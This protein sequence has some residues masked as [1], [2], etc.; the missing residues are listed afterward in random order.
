MPRT[1]EDPSL[2]VAECLSQLP[3]TGLRLPVPRSSLEGLHVRS[4]SEAGG[5][6]AQRTPDARQGA[7]DGAGGAGAPFLVLEGRL[8]TRNPGWSLRDGECPLAG[9]SAV[10]WTTGEVAWTATCGSARCYRCS[11]IVSGRTFALARRAMGELEEKRVRFVTLTLA[12]EEWDSLRKRM[13]DLVQYLRR[14]GIRVNWLWVVEEGSET[15]MK[16]IHCVQWGDF[17]PWRDLLGWWGA[18]V[19]VE[20]SDAAVGYLGK[21]I[22]RYLGKGLDGDREAIEGHMNLNG[23][24]AAHWSRGF[25]AGLSREAF[26]REHRLPGI[27]FLRNEPIGEA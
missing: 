13:K 15:G 2:Q 26:A 24:R 6:L 19:Q 18:R 4:D 22:I 11:R 16:H 1:D 27:Y 3:A 21:N 20:A 9:Y 8:D 17:I 25:F 7:S 23:G 14:R 10:D 5:E 12:P